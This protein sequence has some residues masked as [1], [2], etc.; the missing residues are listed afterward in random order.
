M[1]REV[2]QVYT[3]V[4]LEKIKNEIECMNK[5]QHI[6]VLKILKRHKTIKLNE[7]KNGVYINLSFLSKEI[8]EELEK[9]IKYVNDQNTILQENNEYVGDQPKE[10]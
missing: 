1:E 7:N 6:E 8:I 2:L 10:G 3:D 5:V 9:Y 4:F